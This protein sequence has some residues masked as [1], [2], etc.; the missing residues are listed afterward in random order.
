MSR[1]NPSKNPEFPSFYGP[2][3]YKPKF[4]HTGPVFTNMT[5]PD[6]KIDCD[7]Y[8]PKKYQNITSPPPKPNTPRKLSKKVRFNMEP[9]RMDFGPENFVR[10]PSRTSALSISPVNSPIN[11]PMK[12]RVSSRTSGFTDLDD[13]E[14]SSTLNISQSFILPSS[15]NFIDLNKSVSR[16]YDLD[17]TDNSF[18]DYSPKKFYNPI[19]SNVPTGEFKQTKPQQSSIRARVMYYRPK[20]P[21]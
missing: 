20:K 13:T 11:T 3:S 15:K 8:I 2:T 6:V 1:K 16:G 5:G 19:S 12:S 4:T 9:N 7:Y 10:T 18:L 21:L 17:E 14:D